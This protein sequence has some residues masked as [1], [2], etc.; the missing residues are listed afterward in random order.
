MQRVPHDV[1]SYFLPQPDE[2]HGDKEI[3]L[4]LP[5]RE[6]SSAS[7]LTKHSELRLMDSIDPADLWAARYVKTK[8]EQLVDMWN[9]AAAQ[10]ESEIVRWLRGE[11]K[12]LDA[13]GPRGDKELVLVPYDA[14]EA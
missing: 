1:K 2:L 7:V 11:G 3:H 5:Y 12:R 13:R 8:D 6:E 9:L 14:P 10:F 4:W